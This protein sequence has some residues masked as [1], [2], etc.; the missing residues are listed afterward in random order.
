M[1]LSGLVSVLSRSF[2]TSSWVCFLTTICILL[3]FF[4]ALFEV[5]LPSASPVSHLCHKLQQRELL[6]H[7]LSSW[8][9]QS[10]FQLE[11]FIDSLNYGYL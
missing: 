4:R 11:D 8:N 9:K 3:F 1:H 7:E 6:P 10:Q 5:V 2:L